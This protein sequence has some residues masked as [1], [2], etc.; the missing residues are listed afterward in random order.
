MATSTHAV[1]VALLV[2]LVVGAFK[3]AAFVLTGSTAI[4]AEVLHS[5]ADLTNQSL[6]AVGIAQSR[7]APD[8]DYPYGFG[9]SRYIWA[10]LSAAGVLFVGSGVSVVRGA[11]RIWAPEP[12]EHLDWGFIILLVS[13][14]AESVSLAVGWSSVRRSA[15]Q[16]GQSVWQYLRRGADPMGVAVVLED[17]SAVLGVLI[18]MTGL[19][20]AELTG[21]AAWDGAASVGIGLLLGGSAVFLI[22]RNRRHLLGAAPSSESVAQMTAVLEESPLVARIQDVKVSQL[23]ADAVRFK[24]EVT[25]DGRELA[26]RL[27]AERDLDA[28]W[29]ALNGPQALERLLVEF[30]GEVTDAIG[31]EIDRLE[32]ELSEVAPEARHVDLEPD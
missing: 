18:A 24:A 25:F 15:L 13:L 8:R 31:D 28:T 27:L 11:Q 12:L 19:G 4:M 26:R 16:A 3:L 22:N 5:A 20:L 2:D 10:L 23:G 9:R 14:A 7:R 30:G 32:G 29:A 6:L 1:A 17:A 21:N